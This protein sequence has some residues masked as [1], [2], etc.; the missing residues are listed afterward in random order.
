VAVAQAVEAVAP[1]FAFRVNAV[2]TLHHGRF[3]PA[4][5]RLLDSA[6]EEE[7]GKKRSAQGRVLVGTQTLEQS[8]DIDADLLIT[9]LCPI[10]VLLQRIGRLHRH[11]R[12]D[13][14]GFGEAR[15]IVLVPDER[16]FSRYLSRMADRH[17][18]G[19]LSNGAGVYSDLLVIEATLRLIEANRVVDI[20]SDN[21]RLVEGALHPEVLSELAAELGVEWMN[22]A[23]QQSGIAIYQRGLARDLALDVRQPFS[24]L[25]FPPV[26]EKVATRLGTQDRA[27]NF[28]PPVLG[29]FGL[30]VWRLT[31]PAWMSSGI[32]Q[33]VEPALIDQNSEGFAFRLGDK[34]FR[35]GRFGLAGASQ[36]TFEH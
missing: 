2:A 12:R 11:D 34:Y 10:D 30:L 32:G 27:V 20:P 6:V 7:F 22:H 9:D 3:A 15:A 33:E 19:P 21:R 35:Y 29:P 24:E 17:G 31:I 8:L 13:R 4:D 18:L 16:D 14:G 25:L 5:R 28:D 36:S 1:E 26:D 23:A